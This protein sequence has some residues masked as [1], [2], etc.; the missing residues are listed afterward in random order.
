MD[1]TQQLASEVARK[2][3]SSL[4]YRNRYHSDTQF[5]EKEKARAATYIEA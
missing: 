2:E 5:R 1:D 4:Y 3:A